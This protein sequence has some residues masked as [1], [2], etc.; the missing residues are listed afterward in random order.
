MVVAHGPA[1]IRPTRSCP[2]AMSCP[3]VRSLGVS[4]VAPEP[5]LRRVPSWLK[6]LHDRLALRPVLRRL[7]FLAGRLPR[8]G[9][10]SAGGGDRGGL[11]RGGGGHGG[12]RRRRRGPRGPAPRAAGSRWSST[13]ATWAPRR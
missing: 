9:P 7:R 6:C 11:A 3:T 1:P 4:L 10:A 13:S 5:H 12:R 8:G 2:S